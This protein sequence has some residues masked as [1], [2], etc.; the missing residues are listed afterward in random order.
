M[1]IP[2][3][4]GKIFVVGPHYTGWVDAA[5]FAS[6]MEGT[7]PTF[8]A[9]D[10]FKRIL[11]VS[12]LMDMAGVILVPAERTQSKPGQKSE[13][14]LACEVLNKNG[15]ITLFPQGWF[16]RTGQEPPIVRH[17]A[18]QMALKSKK[19]IY[20]YRLDGYPSIEKA[21]LPLFIINNTFY[22]TFITALYPN[23]VTVKLCRV[24]DEHLKPENAHLTDDQR[25]KLIDK[26]CADIFGS[27]FVAKT[28]SPEQYNF[29][30]TKI[31]D[32]THLT[33]WATRMKQLGLEKQLKGANAPAEQALLEKELKDTKKTA[34]DQVD[35]VLSE[36]AVRCSM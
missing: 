14:D 31:A 4:A 16:S 27:Y 11:F 19:P 29:I 6:K 23:N 5:V 32:K 8:L 17:G 9:T 28:L 22:R 1:K 13:V 20:V 2:D 21:W 34:A 26:I 10:L 18:A 3:G 36:M 12:T 24:I 33:I 25:L 7:P 15:N 30:E 35:A